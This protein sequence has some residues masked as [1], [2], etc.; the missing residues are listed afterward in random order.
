[1][2][3][4]D[5]NA[6]DDQRL[7]KCKKSTSTNRELASR[8]YEKASNNRLYNNDDARKV[9]HRRNKLEQVD[10][11]ESTA[12]RKRK[13]D[14][15]ASDDQRLS[16]CPKSPSTSRE[17]ASRKYEKRP[18]IDCTIT[19]T[20]EKSFI[21]GISLSKSTKLYSLPTESA[22]LIQMPAMINVFQSKASNNRLYN[23]DD[24][25]KVIHRR[26]KNEKVD[27][28][29]FTADRKCKTDS[30]ASD[31]QRLL[32][33]PKSTSTNRELA[34]RKYE[35]ASNDH[36]Q[37]YN[38]GDARKVI[39]R[40]DKREQ[41]NKA[42][43]TADRKRKTD[44]NASDDQRLS[45][46]KKST[47]TN[48]ESASRKYEK[49]SNNRL[50]SNDDARKVIHRRNKLEQVDKVESTADRKRKTDSNASDGQQLLKCPKSTSTNRELASRKYEKA[51][52]NRL[53]SNNDARKVIHR[54]NKIE[55]VDK[56]E[57]TA[58]RKRK[59]DSNAS[60]GQRFLKCPK[61]TSTNREL[62]SRKY[63]KASNNRLYNNDDA[64]KVIHRRNK[65]EQV[66]KVEFTADR[67]RK[68]GSNASDDQR[69]SKCP[70][71][72]STSRESA[73]R[74]YEKRPMIDCTITT[75]PEKSFIEGISLSKSTK[76]Y[77]L[78]TESA[79]LIQMP[80]MDR[81][82]IY[83]RTIEAFGE[84][85]LSYKFYR[86][87]ELPDW[88]NETKIPKPSTIITIPDA[89]MMARLSRPKLKRSLATEYIKLAEIKCPRNLLALSNS[90]DPCDDEDIDECK[91]TKLSINEKFSKIEMDNMKRSFE[92]KPLI[93][94][95]EKGHEAEKKRIKC[96]NRGTNTD[97]DEVTKSETDQL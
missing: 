68:T 76:L 4:T 89:T 33:C 84:D 8:K 41:V 34:S 90:K 86:V 40:R 83:E 82:F 9:I 45:K 11:V 77:S 74:K 25:R 38:D 16:K 65:L 59:T 1:M 35:K 3:K 80:A 52:N 53:Y 30:N 54:R 78:P 13:T 6:S 95:Y 47:S 61:S 57:F 60:D 22:K 46:C 56:V 88:L 97:A 62:A 48:R 69:L 92:K 10:K 42:L 39:H 73:S 37:L 81:R 21:E 27:K 64:R 43:F 66:D 20:P 93:Q 87:H 51:S 94:E 63:E 24:A 70:K 96:T 36:D 67:K 55:Q 50:Y 75:T 19:T 18:M 28:V 44:S 14:S 91:I 79:K 2:R 17:S 58:D 32:K 72:S 26:N 23:N 7:P 12:D 29:E 85:W 5:S 49:A 31:G 71:S 15:I